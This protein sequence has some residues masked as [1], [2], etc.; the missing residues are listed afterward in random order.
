MPDRQLTPEELI[1]FKQESSTGIQF[2]ALK[3]LDEER[4]KPTLHDLCL[5]ELK[6]SLR[7]QKNVI[8]ELGREIE[9]LKRKEAE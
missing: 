1:A 5:I 7:A 9:R 6:A 4:T 8:I 3:I 2:N